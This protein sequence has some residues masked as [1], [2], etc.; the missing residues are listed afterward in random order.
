[1]ISKPA[2]NHDDIRNLVNTTLQ[3]EVLSSEPLGLE[4]LSG[5]DNTN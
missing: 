3:D 2:A 4:D 5:V 1:M